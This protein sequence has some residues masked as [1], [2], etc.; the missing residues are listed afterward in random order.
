MRVI[1]YTIVSLKFIISNLSIVS[2][3]PVVDG[4]WHAL[5]SKKLLEEGEEAKQYTAVDRISSKT[6]FSHLKRST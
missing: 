2:V 3:F 5:S 4:G 1:G 6:C